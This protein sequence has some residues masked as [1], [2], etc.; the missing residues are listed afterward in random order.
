MSTL[1]RSE[2]LSRGDSLA[3]E[4]LA[5]LTEEARKVPSTHTGAHNCISL[6]TPGI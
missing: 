1:T 5:N 4:V 6:G 2:K 3:A